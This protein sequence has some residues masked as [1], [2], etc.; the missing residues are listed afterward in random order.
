MTLKLIDFG[1]SST[2]ENLKNKNRIIGTP[3]YIAPE[4]F[5]K[6]AKN[7]KVD[8]YSCGI[9]LYY[10]LCGVIPFREKTEKNIL[11]SN[12]R[13]CISFQRYPCLSSEVKSFIRRLTNSDP[14]FRP[15]AEEAL[16]HKWFKKMLRSDNSKKS[17][18]IQLQAVI[19]SRSCNCYDDLNKMMEE[20]FERSFLETRKND[21][22]SVKD[23]FI[24][25]IDIEP[26]VNK[27]KEFM[28]TTKKSHDESKAFASYSRIEASLNNTNGSD[29][30]TSLKNLSV[31]YGTL[32]KKVL[33]KTICRTFSINLMNPF[34]MQRT[35]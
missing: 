31:T 16:K 23:E 18:S 8:I 5:H 2:K 12:K 29:I 27:V 9:T 33:H 32:F 22:A 1:L 19:K 20:A 21:C 17:S 13:N 35:L 34:M 24:E 3:G 4:L 10:M 11:I 15:S 7:E 26:P 30:R 14:D 6:I 25:F 28:I